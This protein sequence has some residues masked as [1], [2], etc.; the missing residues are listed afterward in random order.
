[1][2]YI[3]TFLVLCTGLWVAAQNK[4]SGKIIDQQT[5]EPLTGATVKVINTK[6]TSLTD[7]SGAFT[8]ES[9]TN[10]EAIEIS[11]I[12]YETKRIALGNT[13]G[14][15]NIVL[16]A[17]TLNLNSVTV[18]GYE[19]N[20]KLSETAGA[21]SIL[22]SKE[23]QRGDNMDIMPAL[24]T[25]PG[26]KM[27]AYV[28]GDYRISIRGSLLNN[29]WGIRNVKLYWNDIPLSSPDGTASHGVDF[30]P[31]MIGSIEILK[32]P[33]G[34]IYGAG[35]GGVLLFK[36]DRAFTGQN[37]L[38][39]GYTAGSYG[40]GK[41][42][43]AYKTGTNNFNLAANYTHQRY[44]GYRENGW[45][46]KDVVNIFAQFLPGEKRTVN[47][48]VNY[49]T[50][51]FGLMGGLDSEQ[52]AQNPRQAIQYAKDNKTSVKRY[53]VAQFGASQTYHFNDKFFNTTSIYASMQTLDHPYGESE[54]YNGYLKEST[55]GLGARTKFVYAPQ[56]GNIKSRFTLGAEFMYQHQFGNTYT[57][58]NDV[59]DTWPETG[60][61]FQSLITVSKSN[62]IFAQAEFDLPWR[63][64]LTAGASYN[65]LSYDIT[66]L[67]KDS[68]HVNYSGLIDF[69]KKISPR[70]GLVKVVNS[71][72]SVYGSISYGYSP[73]PLWELNNFDGTLNK[74]IKPEDGQDY[75]LGIR[76]NAFS[77]KFSYDI[78]AYQMF[79]TNAIVPVTNQYGTTSYK[80]AGS[81]NQKG[82]EAMLMFAAINNPNKNISLL[83]LW[84]SFT[85]NNYKFR[86]YV[87]ESFNWD[88]NTVI[89]SDYSGNEVTGVVPVSV[90]AGI[91]AAT[92]A[93]LY[94]N[95]VFYYYD[96]S[97]MNDANTAYN[98]AYSL[99]NAK[100]GFR[101]DIKQWLAIDV[102]A[103]VNNLT[104]TQYSS[105]INFNADANAYGAPPAW[106]NP[107]PGS[108]FYGGLKL[109]F[110][111][112]K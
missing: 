48:F 23:I 68:A 8:I 49:A 32:G 40:F 70:I 10:I 24:N 103:G 54:Y 108:N 60:D 98:K 39:T 97:P 76:G 86:D 87:A 17:S 25:V 69:P 102:F 4:V 21:I 18:T 51:T 83:R 1:M 66:D 37:K 79:I 112:A 84:T 28:T 71:N 63:L 89:K 109:T 42:S 22:K 110:N 104:N 99:L 95:T 77:N 36:S 44:D 43:T 30:D 41:W 65:D 55:E 13:S 67:Y 7:K 74:D 2:K 3:F 96:K 73:P 59:P 94:F 31:T 5:N 101:E 64:L 34:S 111:F 20:R 75:E 27:E 26:V 88:N 14:F 78:T 38:E 62:I 105:L 45:S 35:N 72:L 58:V 100:L 91:D 47:L 52:V 53:N 9:K 57:I 11:Y 6:N 50:G 12:G 46:D 61:L 81:T 82:V 80:N 15:L 90:S 106:Y 56:L 107:S 16:T 33:S 85:Y 19:N 29:P 92:K 93:G